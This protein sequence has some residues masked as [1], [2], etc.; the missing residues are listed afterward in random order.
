MVCNSFMCGKSII[1]NKKIKNQQ[2]FFYVSCISKMI[3]W[4]SVFICLN[5]KSYFYSL[6][7]KP[8][9]KCFE[10]YKILKK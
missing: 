5:K 8:M 4:F 6:S 1:G 2:Y 9:S 7:L 3:I 10:C